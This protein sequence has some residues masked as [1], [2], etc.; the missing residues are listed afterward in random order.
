MFIIK[1][2]YFPVSEV[3][4]YPVAGDSTLGQKPVKREHSPDEEDGAVASKKIKLE[5][6][7]DN[8]SW[9]LRYIQM[10]HKKLSLIFPKSGFN[11]SFYFVTV[12][13]AEKNTQIYF[14][15][16][17][18]TQKLSATLLSACFNGIKYLHFASCVFWSYESNP[19]TAVQWKD[20]SLIKCNI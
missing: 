9:M 4:T 18:L 14:D 10:R 1:H 13:V 19:I 12:M 5:D 11:R 17:I 20:D 16:Q 2:E 15:R 6:G 8:V 3:F 7:A